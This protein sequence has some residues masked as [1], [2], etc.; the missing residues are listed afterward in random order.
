MQLRSIF[1]TV[2]ILVAGADGTADA[3]PEFQLSTGNGRCSLCHI[4]PTGGGLINDYG[5]SE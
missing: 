1:L 3:Y 5:R 4:S 2:A